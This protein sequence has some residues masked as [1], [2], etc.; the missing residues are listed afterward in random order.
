MV[1]S[2]GKLPIKLISTYATL[3]AALHTI[4]GQEFGARFV[5]K[6]VNQLEIYLREKP[7]TKEATN[8][9]HFLVDLFLLK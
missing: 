7:E 3:P 8:L 6:C 9:V 5:Q 1:C 4:V 2:E